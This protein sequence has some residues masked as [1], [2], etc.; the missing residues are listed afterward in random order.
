MT[1][2]LSRVRPSLTI[3][4]GRLRVEGEGLLGSKCS[5]P[6]VTVGGG[7][8]HVVAASD[9]AVTVVVPASTSGGAQP[10][11]L[12]TV[13][14]GSIVIRVGR[15]IATGIHQV[16]S[17]AIDSRGRVYVT[18]SG[19]RGEHA[20]VSV[21]RI[22]PGGLRDAFV[23]GI[24]NPTAMAIGPDDHLYVSSRFDGT[25][26]R[27][28][29]DGRPEAFASDLGVA[30]GLAFTKDGTLFVGDR[31]GTIFRVV[32]G[33]QQARVHATLPPSV[34]AFHLASASDGTL[35]VTGPTLSTLD[36]V[37]R[38]EPSGDVH[39][40]YTG[41]G[42]PQGVAVS[43]DGG[44]YVVEALAGVSGVYKLR[45]DAPP[46]LVVSGPDL[47]GLAFR[48]DGGLVVTTADTAYEFDTVSA[49]I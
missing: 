38:I 11:R 30:C 14:G 46:E 43:A 37:Y 8:A 40:I 15:A 44:L 41:F 39:A 48:P 2:T 29:D 33:G 31:S 25:V 28:D 17:P 22:G 5:A 1:A 3:P 32:P 16:D 35:Y 45:D 9:S 47:I 4:G 6:R 20:P 36:K 18:Y 42:R 13:P 27:I 24:T 34:A 21:F 7:N 49:E 12:A 10:L 23:T 26:Y 19:S